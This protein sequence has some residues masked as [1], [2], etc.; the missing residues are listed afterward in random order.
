MLRSFIVGLI[1]NDRI[2]VVSS[3]LS[4]IDTLGFMAGSPL[5]AELFSRGLA[6]G[7]LW[8]GLPFYFLGVCGICFAVL[9]LVVGL[10][11]GEGYKDSNDI[12]AG[13]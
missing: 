13:Q 4:L 9:T 6:M 11:K 5:M 2:A 10:R 1:P 7:D 3:F 12:D 8:I